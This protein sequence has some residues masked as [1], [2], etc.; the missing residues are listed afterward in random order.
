MNQLE[1]TLGVNYVVQTRKF[2]AIL[3]PSETMQNQYLLWFNILKK[4]QV[5][6]ATQN[7][8][9]HLIQ[10]T[11]DSTQL[12]LKILLLNLRPPTHIHNDIVAALYIA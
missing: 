7:I 4:A 5:G 1:F 9:Q 8:E 10:N 12:E 2:K 6:N 3:N 11:Y